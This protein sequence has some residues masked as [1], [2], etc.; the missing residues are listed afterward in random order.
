MDL[1]K[2][3]TIYNSLCKLVLAD[4]Q[5]NVAKNLEQEEVS[6]D[7]FRLPALK[8]DKEKQE[9]LDRKEKILERNNI[10]PIK[11]L[12]KGAYNVVFETVYNGKQAVAKLTQSYSDVEN[13]LKLFNLKQSLGKYSKHILDIYDI[14]KD[15]PWYII[16]AEK[17]EP[18]N[19]HVYKALFNYREPTTE[20]INGKK[21]EIREIF[22][23]PLN[24]DNKLIFKLIRKI[25]MK[26]EYRIPEKL[27]NKYAKDILD[28]YDTYKQ[29]FIDANEEPKP[30][31]KIM[32]IRDDML[33][34]IRFQFKSIIDVD[35]LR[36]ILD[37]LRALFYTITTER[38]PHNSNNIDSEQI[39]AELPESQ[40]IIKLLRI[41]RQ[42]Y[43]IDYTDLHHNNIMERPGTRD[44]VLSD[45]GL[46]GS[47]N[48]HSNALTHKL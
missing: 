35:T 44:L 33:K 4:E 31:E 43:N 30:N 45:P 17:L 26:P 38:F 25:L 22:K 11:Y 7:K 10:I 48:V 20:L 8:E 5:S 37:D 21:K 12:G 40:S 1:L 19:E 46:F 42:K 6:E 3:S 14:K 23:W 13:L 29:W 39:A 16:I 2:F 24:I 32:S 34:N 15:G 36:N 47:S 41:L 28:I 18:I 9:Y 27:C